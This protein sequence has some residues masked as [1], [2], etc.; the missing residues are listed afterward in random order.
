M[1]EALTNA[2]APVIA[3]SPIVGGRAIKEPA[4]KMMTELKMPVS[5]QA[6]AAYYGKLLDGIIIDRED[7]HP[8][9]ARAIAV[10]RHTNTAKPLLW[11]ERGSPSDTF[12]ILDGKRIAARMASFCGVTLIT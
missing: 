1:R 12:H 7:A 9:H 8:A 6:V 10:C 2:S 4:A 11:W 3:V 5:A